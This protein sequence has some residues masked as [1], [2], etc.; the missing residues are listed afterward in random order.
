MLFWGSKRLN[1]SLITSVKLHT[2]YRDFQKNLIVVYFVVNFY[3][4][5]YHNDIIKILTHQNHVKTKKNVFQNANRIL[6]IQ[7]KL[8][9]ST[10][11]KSD[12]LGFY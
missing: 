6:K 9:S 4:V 8:F 2:L 5:C 11:I 3:A 12:A 7:K 1:L 10:T